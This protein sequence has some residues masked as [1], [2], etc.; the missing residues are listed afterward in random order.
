M[1]NKIDFEEYNEPI[2]LF[3]KDTLDKMEDILFCRYKKWHKDC[4]YNATEYMYKSLI[5]YMGIRLL[6]RYDWTEEE[7]KNMFLDITDWSKTI[8]DDI[9]KKYKII[10]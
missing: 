7:L 3:V 5:S 8:S 4:Y 6:N 9:D 10:N 2:E 1:K